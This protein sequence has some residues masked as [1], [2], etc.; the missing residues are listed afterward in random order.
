MGRKSRGKQERRGA[1]LSNAQ[2]PA[3]TAF[4]ASL[5]HA[6]YRSGPMP[7]ANELRA[8]EEILPGT[9]QVLVN[10]VVEQS[11]HRK[12]L[13]TKVVHHGI[14]QS[15]IGQ[16]S[17]FVIGAMVVWR[18]TEIMLQGQEVSGL[19]GVLSGLGALVGLY[20]HGK[21]AKATELDQRRDS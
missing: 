19:I 7:D 16:V 11:E 20:L 13:E 17:A 9:A 12:K 3:P 2:R 14:V 4:Q 1:E 18:S 8:Y 21:R 15:Y 6:E 5:F 10:Q